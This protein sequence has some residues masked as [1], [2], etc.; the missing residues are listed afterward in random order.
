MH[1]RRVTGEEGK[2]ENRKRSNVWKMKGKSLMQLIAICV[3]HL[4]LGSTLSSFSPDTMM[5]VELIKTVSDL[6]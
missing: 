6:V 2:K 3:S 4:E 5:K 1:S